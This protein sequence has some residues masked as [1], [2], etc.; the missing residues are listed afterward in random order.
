MIA[1]KVAV[2]QLNILKDP[3]KNLRKI[4]KVVRRVKRNNVDLLLLPEYCISEPNDARKDFD[5][6]TPLKKYAKENQ[7]YI[8]GTNPKK[9]KD[10]N[11]YN[12]GFSISS[13]GRV[14]L[15]QRKISLCPLEKKSGVKKGK[16]LEVV[17]T[18]FGE[19]GILVCKDSFFR[20]SAEFF[21][22]L[23]KLGADIILVP[24]WEIKVMKEELEF[25]KTS[26]IANCRGVQL[27]FSWQM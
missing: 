15:K 2:A 24:T 23:R 4:K 7:V 17:S 26:L 21:N 27:M 14:I 18:K 20:Y 1:P 9:E 25:F 11:V 5:F 8:A 19:I 12:I 6:L 22:V 16:V 13:T 10:G 3:E